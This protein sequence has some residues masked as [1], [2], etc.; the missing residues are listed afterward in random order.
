M[1]FIHQICFY[2]HPSTDTASNSTGQ[3]DL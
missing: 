1:E 2:I 3:I